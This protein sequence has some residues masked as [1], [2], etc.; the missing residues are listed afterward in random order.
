MT[1]RWEKR[2]VFHLYNEPNRRSRHHRPS[3]LIER[4]IKI[5][6]RPLEI[7]VFKINKISI[8]QDEV[9]I[10][11]REGSQELYELPLMLII[12][13]AG[14]EVGLGLQ[15]TERDLQTK[16]LNYVDVYQ[17]YQFIYYSNLEKK[18]I[19]KSPIAHEIRDNLSVV[20]NFFKKEKKG[21]IFLF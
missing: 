16:L 6:P 19:E 21:V 14:D 17:D 13:P 10:T 5:D 9:T 18:E 8:D 2:I 20:N 7:P 12:K 15:L 4:L 1:A 3:G 11:D